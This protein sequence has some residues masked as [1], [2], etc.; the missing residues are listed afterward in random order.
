MK[1]KLSLRW[2]TYEPLESLLKRAL[3]QGRELGMSKKVLDKLAED[4][5]AAPDAAK[6][7]RVIGSVFQLVLYDEQAE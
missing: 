1:P 5:L 7:I 6:A 2:G 4:F 3:K